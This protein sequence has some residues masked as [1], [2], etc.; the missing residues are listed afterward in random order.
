MVVG[1]VALF[2]AWLAVMARRRRRMADAWPSPRNLQIAPLVALTHSFICKLPH[3]YFIF[4]IRVSRGIARI[5]EVA[6]QGRT[7]QAL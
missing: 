4:H 2:V 3:I 1:V 6:G 5:N 7:S